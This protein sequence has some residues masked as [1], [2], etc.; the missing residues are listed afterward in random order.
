MDP[1]PFISSN[2]LKINS[3]KQWERIMVERND[4]IELAR[5]WRRVAFTLLAMGALSNIST[6]GRFS[7]W[8]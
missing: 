2:R 1:K 5:F 8:W 7:G 6:L 4:A 3:A